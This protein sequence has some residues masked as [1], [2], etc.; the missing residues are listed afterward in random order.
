MCGIFWVVSIAISIALLQS[1]RIGY[2]RCC[3]HSARCSCCRATSL[4]HKRG[5]LWS[6]V[7]SSLSMRRK[8]K[9]FSFC[10]SA[11]TWRVILRVQRCT[12]LISLYIAIF[13]SLIWI[14]VPWTAASL[15]GTILL[16]GLLLIGGKS[17]CNKTVTVLF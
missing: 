16:V 15:L 8:V 10:W 6:R 11:T 17:S 2:C 12:L 5:A 14:F 3:R 13:V 1:H 4:R 9:D 7:R